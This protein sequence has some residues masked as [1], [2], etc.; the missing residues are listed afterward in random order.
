MA[1]LPV[2]E[3]QLGGPEEEWGEAGEEGRKVRL[4]RSHAIRDSASPPPPERRE[5]REEVRRERREEREEVR[6]IVSSEGGEVE[7]TG[8][9]AVAGEVEGRPGC[10]MVVKVVSKYERRS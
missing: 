7:G 3:I 8:G 2:P 9:E 6:S 1:H 4:G 5:E 10:R